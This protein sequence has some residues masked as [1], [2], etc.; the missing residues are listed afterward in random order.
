MTAIRKIQIDDRGND[1]TAVFAE[2]WKWDHV[3]GE[4]QEDDYIVIRTTGGRPVYVKMS[5][6]RELASWLLEHAIDPEPAEMTVADQVRSRV[7]NS[8]VASSVSF[9]GGGGA[10]G[11]AIGY[12]A[13]GGNGGVGGFAVVPKMEQCEQSAPHYGH[14]W[15]DG[16]RLCEGVR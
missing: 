14:T 2:W 13:R 5:D 3:D 10:G 11:V 7:A 6:A 15:K 8:A 4:T 16:Q 12:G 9:G 1:G